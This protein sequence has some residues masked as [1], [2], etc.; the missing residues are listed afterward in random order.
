[1]RE[2]ESVKMSTWLASL[3]STV[4]VVLG[5]TLGGLQFYRAGYKMGLKHAEINSEIRA[6][7]LSCTAQEF[8]IAEKDKFNEYLRQQIN[9]VILENDILKKSN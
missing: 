5:L 7:E 1:M 2:Y 6:Y 3:I 4:V 9:E 8:A